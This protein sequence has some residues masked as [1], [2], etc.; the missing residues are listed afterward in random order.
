MFT[1]SGGIQE[2]TTV[3]GVQ[4]VTLRNNTEHPVTVTNGTNH[5]AGIEP[6]AIHRITDDISTNWQ[7]PDKFSELW[8]GK[9]AEQIIEINTNNSAAKK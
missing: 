2:E 9:A 7:E 4:C 6:K 8:D 5:L 1:D 3:F